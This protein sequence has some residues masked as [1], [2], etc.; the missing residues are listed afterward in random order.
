M[1]NTRVVSS[2]DVFSVSSDTGLATI[3]KRG[4]RRVFGPPRPVV[5]GK[6]AFIAAFVPQELFVGPNV[7]TVPSKEIGLSQL[8]HSD[9]GRV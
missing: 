9:T 3:E 8:V 7:V 2:G 5:V 1:S 6:I 4:L